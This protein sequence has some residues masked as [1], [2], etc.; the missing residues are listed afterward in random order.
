MTSSP[1]SSSA[2]KHRIGVDRRVA[3]DELH[4]GPEVQLT[5]DDPA[6]RLLG[7]PAIRLGVLDG[8]IA[9]RVN[10]QRQRPE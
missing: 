10:V 1:V 9:Q 6:Q 5:L 3:I 4:D 7:R 2:D 8:R